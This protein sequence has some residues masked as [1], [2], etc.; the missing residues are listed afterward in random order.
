MPKKKKKRA[1][2]ENGSQFHRAKMFLVTAS[3]A[4]KH[5]TELPKQSVP[6]MATQR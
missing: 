6:R 3:L 1:Q 2:F 5:P 4:Y